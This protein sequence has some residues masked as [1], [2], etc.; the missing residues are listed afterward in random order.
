MVAN[1]SEI[2][3]TIPRAFSTPT[4]TT[5]SKAVTSELK[6]P[7]SPLPNVKSFDSA[8]CTAE[9]VVSALRVAGGVVVRGVLNKDELARLE[10]D[11]RLWLEMDREWGEGGGEGT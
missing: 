1:A 10:A 2:P 11:T 7:H 8:S 5:T 4:T 3:G 6:G 9:E